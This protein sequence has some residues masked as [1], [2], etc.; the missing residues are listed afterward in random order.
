[1][2]APAIATPPAVKERPI[3]FSGPMVRAIRAGLKTQTRRVMKPQPSDLLSLPRTPPPRLQEK[4]W[5]IPYF[6]A[7]CGAAKT[8]ANPRGMTEHW[9]WWDEYDRQGP[10]WIRCPFGVPGDRLWLR[11]TWARLTGNGVRTVFRADADPPLSLID[12]KPVE[13]MKWTP[14][15]YMPRSVSRV[16]LEIEDVRAERLR[17]IS[18]ADAIAE[19]VEPFFT[20][21]PNW[22]REQRLTSGEL[23]AAAEHRAAYAVLWDELNADRGFTWLSNCWVWVITFRVLEGLR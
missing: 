22:G 13:H 10:D 23:C 1:M 18:E 12:Q 2:T 17:A 8:A 16:L 11:E 5:A 15:I 21:F 20:R 14:A 3:L 6:D 7:Y 19:G 9:C 4:K